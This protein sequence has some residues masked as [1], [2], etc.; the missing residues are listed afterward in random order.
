MDGDGIGDACDSDNDNDGIED[1]FV[2]ITQPTEQ[3]ESVLHTQ[4]SIIIS[5]VSNTLF[6]GIIIPLLPSPSSPICLRTIVHL[7]IT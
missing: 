5:L 4:A 6:V 7:L 3:T 2:S 1:E